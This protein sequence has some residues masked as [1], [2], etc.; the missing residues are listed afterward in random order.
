ML[1]NK[2]S[3]SF[4]I[5]N[6][7][8]VKWPSRNCILITCVKWFHLYKRDTSTRF[9]SSVFFHELI[10]PC[11]LIL[12][13]KY[14]PHLLGFRGSIHQRSFNLYVC[15]ADIKKKFKDLPKM[16][17]WLLCHVMVPFSTYIYVFWFSSSL[18]TCHFCFL[19]R[20]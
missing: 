9:W 6:F 19:P 14:F 18:K 11:P 10:V 20:K 3:D 8:K 15:N 12:A 16:C 4:Y 2:T 7:W 17:M 13:L 5:L 1:Y